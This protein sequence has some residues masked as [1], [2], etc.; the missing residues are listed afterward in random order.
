M[1]DNNLMLNEQ[2][3]KNNVINMIPFFKN[4][5]HTYSQAITLNKEEINPEVYTHKMIMWLS[6][7]FHYLPPG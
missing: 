4:C 5:E 2:G 3:N 7:D 6:V 1:K